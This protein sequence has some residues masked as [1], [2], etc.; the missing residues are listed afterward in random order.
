MYCQS[1]SY[2]PQFLPSALF[3]PFP[4]SCQWSAFKF[5][6]IPKLLRPKLEAGLEL[7]FPE[8][9][10]SAFTVKSPALQTNGAS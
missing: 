5:W 4:P 10:Y 9:Y 2:D 7:I 8:Y 1:Y 6:A 3:Y